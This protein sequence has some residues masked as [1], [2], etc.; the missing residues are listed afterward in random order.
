MQDVIALPPSGCNPLVH[1]S[2]AV[3][4]VCRSCPLIKE[5][6]EVMTEVGDH[7]SL[8]ASLKQAAYFHLFKVVLPFLLRQ[9]KKA[10]ASALGTTP[11]IVTCFPFQFSLLLETILLG[12]GIWRL[13]NPDP[14]LL[15][16]VGCRLSLACSARG[17][18]QLIQCLLSYK[19][20]CLH[21]CREL[22]GYLHRMRQVCGSSG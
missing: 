20:Q 19:S 2:S 18:L 8:V 1:M 13:P 4:R 12:S 5:W 22:L 15:S 6:R 16:S 17:L 14:S 21:D 9:T 7:Q 3:L 11:H 10:G